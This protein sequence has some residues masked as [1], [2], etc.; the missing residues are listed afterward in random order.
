MLLLFFSLQLELFSSMFDEIRERALIQFMPTSREYVESYLLKTSKNI[1][2]FSYFGVGIIFISAIWLSLGI[3]RALNHIWRVKTQRNLILRLATH[4]MIWVFIPVL[5]MLSIS[6]TTWFTS[7]PYLSDLSIHVS[8]F[9]HILPWLTSA[10]ALFLLYFFVPNTKVPF[11]NAVLAAMFAGVLFEISKWGF[12][13]Y[14]TKV[15]MYEKLYGTLAALPVFMIW[16]FISWAIVLWG[17]TF[18]ATLQS[19]QRHL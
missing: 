5:I 7:L 15:A 8:K 16:V 14:I 10:I 17:A 13:V 3:E 11:K 2:S 1:K 19:E 18:C 6:L 4:I 9:S 12:T